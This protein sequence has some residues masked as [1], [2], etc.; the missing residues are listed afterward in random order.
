MTGQPGPSRSGAVR[1]LVMWAQRRAH[2]LPAPAR[3]G[4]GQLARTLIHDRGAAAPEADWRVPLVAGGT[5]DIEDLGPAGEPPERDVPP[6]RAKPVAV[7][8]CAVV[9]G[10]DKGG[11]EEFAAFLARRLPERGV[12]TV[13]VR[14]AD[15]ADDDPLL[16]AL[17]AAGVPTVT[18]LP[19][20]QQWLRTVDPDVVSAH[21]APDWMLDAVAAAGVPWVETLHGMHPFMHPHTWPGERERARRV[22]A[23]VAVSD[24]VR[25]QYLAVN[26]DFPADRVVTV[27]N[28]VDLD[29]APRVDRALARR[30]LGL[31]DEFLFVSL[32]R[33]SLQ[34]NTYGLVSAFAEVAAAH[35]GTHLLVAGHTDDGPYTQQ[36]MRLAR[37]L[38]AADRI[39]LRALCRNPSGLLAAADAFVLDSYFE[40]WSLASMQAMAAGLPVVLSDVGGAREQVG[41]DGAW[42]HLV[43]NPGGDPSRVGWAEIGATRFR[44]QVNRAELVAAMSA[45]VRDRAVWAERRDELAERGRTRFPA[46]A[47]LRRHADVLLGYAR[48]GSGSQLVQ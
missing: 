34:K 2:L 14:A 8:R 33:Y 47:C 17:A 7:R 12:E 41:P 5:G 6:A 19:G 37:S 30:A 42:G 10:P 20:D 36:I 15:T 43:G 39:H 24:L 31:T 18:A 13:F 21:C 1:P 48:P 45:V 16:R 32:A 23:Q 27:P 25:R 4:L 29:R 11:A 44:T 28:G 46:D 3:R 40:G 35:P 22:T 9:T 26:P 38:P